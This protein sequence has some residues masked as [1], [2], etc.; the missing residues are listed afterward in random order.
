MIDKQKLLGRLYDLIDGTG[1]RTEKYAYSRIEQ[2][3][4]SGRFDDSIDK[5]DMA[6]AEGAPPEYIDSGEV[7][8]VVE[9]PNVI[10]A[11][12]YYKSFKCTDGN[13]GISTDSK[14][15]HKALRWIRVPLPQTAPAD[16]G[17]GVQED[18][19]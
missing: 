3:V 19:K 4:L 9:L 8:I 15:R 16:K 7:L 5:P 1:D 12:T 11:L 10:S 6:W 18:E 13:W 17:V 2:E 14:L